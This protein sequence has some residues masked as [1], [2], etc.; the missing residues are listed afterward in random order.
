MLARLH[1]Q[2]RSSGEFV[3][4]KQ[5]QGQANPQIRIA[6]GEGNQHQAQSGDQQA[7]PTFSWAEDQCYSTTQA[8]TEGP[9]LSPNGAPGP[10]GRE[11]E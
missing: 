4:T 3:V 6:S 5:I 1:Q 10:M 11:C 2:S 8:G 9:G 7:G